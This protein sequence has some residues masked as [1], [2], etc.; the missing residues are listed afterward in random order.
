MQSIGMRYDRDT[1]HPTVGVDL[2]VYKLLRSE[3]GAAAPT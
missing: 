2:R 1:T 3:W